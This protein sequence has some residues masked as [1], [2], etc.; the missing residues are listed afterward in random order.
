MAFI[1]NLPFGMLRTKT[2]KF[3]L[4]WMGCVHAPIPVVAAIRILSHTSW[5]YIPLFLLVSV[6]GQIIGARL[7]PQTTVE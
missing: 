4:A 7:K 5:T 6:A 1:L 3:S 2:R